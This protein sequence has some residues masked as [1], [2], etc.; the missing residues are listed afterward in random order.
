MR[1]T[2]T[3]SPPR[4]AVPNGLTGASDNSLHSKARERMDEI[5]RA[6]LLAAVA[7][8]AAERGV[9]N[10][11]VTHVVASA[12]VSRRTFYELFVDGED[13][14]LAAVDDAIDRVEHDVLQS[15]DPKAGWV[16]RIR[17]AFAAILCF[18]D[19]EPGVRQLLLSGPVGRTGHGQ[20]RRGRV[21]AGMTAIVDEGRTLTK[22]G[23]QLPPLTAEGVLGGVL[24][25]LHARL[26]GAVPESAIELLGP[27]MSLI[28]QPYLGTAAARRELERSGPK[29]ARVPT[30]SEGG[31]LAG[32][33][34]RLTYRTVRAL[35][36]VAGNAGASNRVLADAAEV[37]DQ[38]QMSKLLA[39]LEGIGLIENTGLGASRGEPNAWTLTTKGRQVQAALVEQS[40]SV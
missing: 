37:S 33:G 28:V 18:L 29:P 35:T 1:T 38:G 6:R 30:R 40:T 34:M 23:P 22:A 31:L 4:A 26:S 3:A 27:L 2:A 14:L 21:L 17:T 16:E 32:L 39:R 7:E 12:G 19:S 20:D 10:V 11:T 15:Y 36:A 25:V 24:S 9:G 8:V 13:C 5:Q